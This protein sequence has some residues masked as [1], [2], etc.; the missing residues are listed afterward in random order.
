MQFF[1]WFLSIH[2]RDC[3][4]SLFFYDSLRIYTM[5]YCIAKICRTSVVKLVHN[6]KVN[7][8]SQHSNKHVWF[9]GIVHETWRK[10]TCSGANSL[11]HQFHHFAGQRVVGIITKQ[12]I[13]HVQLSFGRSNK[14]LLNEFKHFSLHFAHNYKMKNRFNVWKWFVFLLKHTSSGYVEK[15]VKLFSLIPVSFST[16]VL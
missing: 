4:W 7:S 16:L 10:Y 2:Y 1:F 5:H 13:F 8:H 11:F 6:T 3:F 14:I 9:Q 15:Y 12:G